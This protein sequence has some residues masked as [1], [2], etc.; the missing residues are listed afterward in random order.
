MAG[1]RN[2]G[3][4]EEKRKAGKQEG[5][6]EGGG[7]EMYC[8][9]RTAELRTTNPLNFDWGLRLTLM[10]R[11]CPLS[12]RHHFHSSRLS[13]T[14][15]AEDTE[16]EPAAGVG[17]IPCVPGLPWLIKFGVAPMIRG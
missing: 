10:A 12:I 11:A 1:G 14:E 8:A 3:E 7:G 5:G 9:A 2:G 16:R 6:N 17:L 4:C 13:T 15:Y